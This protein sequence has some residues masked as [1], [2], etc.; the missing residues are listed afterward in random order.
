LGDP[1]PA[2]CSFALP[3]LCCFLRGSFLSF[4]PE[5][6]GHAPP[7][8]AFKA[9][10][11]PANR[12]CHPLEFF[13]FFSLH[14]PSPLPWFSRF[15]FPRSARTSWSFPSDGLAQWCARSHHPTLSSPA[16]SLRSARW[17]SKETMSPPVLPVYF[18][19]AALS[20]IFL[21][22]ACARPHSATKKERVGFLAL[23]SAGTSWGIVPHPFSSCPFLVFFLP[24]YPL[25]FFPE[26]FAIESVRPMVTLGSCPFL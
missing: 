4:P 6:T 8:V 17:S 23:S 24:L 11:F 10:Y 3:L 19:V 21:R 5:G 7:I 20:P 22:A 12:W 18:S 9:A 15:R 2:L 14:P 16:F 26:F 13:P 25:R 1:A